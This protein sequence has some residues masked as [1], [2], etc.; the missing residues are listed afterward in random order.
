MYLN[1]KEK[2]AL[3]LALDALEYGIQN[4]LQAEESGKAIDVICQMLNK[5]KQRRLKSK[6]GS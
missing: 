4:D 5:D 2:V 3:E 1:R 6:K